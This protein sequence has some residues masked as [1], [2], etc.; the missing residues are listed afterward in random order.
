MGQNKTETSVT[1]VTTRPFCHPLNDSMECKRCKR[2]G[3]RLWLSQMADDGGHLALH[4]C[5]PTRIVVHL[6][7]LLG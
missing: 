3:E 5:V 1:S 6:F 2:K 7:Q 4:Q